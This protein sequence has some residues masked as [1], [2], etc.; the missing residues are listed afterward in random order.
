[1]IHPPSTIVSDDEVSESDDDEGDSILPPSTRRPPG[2]PKKHRIRSEHEVNRPKC[3][4]KC[5]RCSGTGH[6]RRTCREAIN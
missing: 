2:R 5:S 4:F 1:M 6:S 3:Q